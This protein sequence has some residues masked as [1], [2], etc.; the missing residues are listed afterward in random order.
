MQLRYCPWDFPTGFCHWN[1]AIEI[2]PLW[3][4][5]WH[6]ATEILPLRVCKTPLL[7]VNLKFHRTTN[8]SH[9]MQLDND[10]K[11]CYCF[12]GY[13]C[14]SEHLGEIQY[15]IS[16]TP[17][18]EVK[19]MMPLHKK[20]QSDKGWDLRMYTWS[21]S[22]LLNFFLLLCTLNRKDQQVFKVPQ[23]SQF[24]KTKPWD[25]LSEFTLW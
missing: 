1:F 21:S 5:H 17:S 9:T 2:L 19:G 23:N 22:Y 8:Y 24:A 4:C 14:W 6:I 15:I 12:T 10:M 18:F 7:S 20:N 11:L 3:C 16:S 13:F 25:R